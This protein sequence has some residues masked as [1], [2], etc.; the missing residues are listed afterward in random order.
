MSG[1]QLWDVLWIVVGVYL[2]LSAYGWLP[3]RPKDPEHP[4]ARRAKVVGI[5]A[6]MLGLLSFLFHSAS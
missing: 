4:L 2:V 6:I 3:G 1:R 5:V